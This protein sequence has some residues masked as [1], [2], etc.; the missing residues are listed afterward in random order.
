MMVI[1]TLVTV[2]FVFVTSGQA[3][4]D[5]PE[6]TGAGTREESIEHGGLKRT[7]R[8]HVPSSYDGSK[9]VPLVLVFHAGG[10]SGRS[11]E[12][13]FGFNRLSD[14]E[15]FL[16][17]YPD[18]IAHQ[19]NDGRI[20]ERFAK[21]RGVD[22]VDFVRALIEHLAQSHKIDPRRIYATGFSSGGFLTH[23]LGWELSDTLAAIGSVAGTLDPR[24]ASRFA[25][26]HPVHVLQIHGSKDV[27]VPYEG[28]EVAGDAAQW[29]R[30]I[31][32]SAM[33]ALWVIADDCKFPSKVENLPENDPNDGTSIQRETYAPGEKGAEVVLYTINGQGHNWAG[34]PAP[35]EVTGPST[36]EIEAAPLIWEF[37][38]THPKG[39]AVRTLDVTGHPGANE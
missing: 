31:P 38:K 16:V 17:V 18:G 9:E 36:A 3:W 30:C 1:R 10:G 23:R 11:A 29:G 2:L 15:G 5:V 6:E 20:G 26:K 13:N 28:G 25:P 4:A 22:D 24:E 12:R 35:S 39:H 34:R 33:I 8:I 14:Q 27:I 37:F 32:A 7:Y 19:L 21:V